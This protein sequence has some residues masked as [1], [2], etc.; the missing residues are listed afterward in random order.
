MKKILVRRLWHLLA[1]AL[2]C[3]C[4]SRSSMM[5]QESFDNVTIGTPIVEVRQKVGEPYSIRSKGGITEEYE[6]VEKIKMGQQLVSENHY[7]LIVSDGRVV[8]KREARKRPPAYDL[9]YQEDPN[10]FNEQY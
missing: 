4:F 1:L 2:L 9:I 10:F 3:S 6:Y 5:T 8:G 7:I